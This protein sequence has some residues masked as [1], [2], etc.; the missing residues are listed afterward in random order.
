MLGY[1]KYSLIDN[2]NMTSKNYKISSQDNN[3]YINNENLNQR[4]IFKKKKI[5]LKGQ[6]KLKSESGV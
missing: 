6:R 4:I 3:I 5:V 2:V 1:H